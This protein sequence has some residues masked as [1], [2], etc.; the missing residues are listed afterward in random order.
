MKRTQQPTNMRCSLSL[1]IFLFRYEHNFL[2]RISLSLSLSANLTNA[3]GGLSRTLAVCIV[4]NMFVSSTSLVSIGILLL[5]SVC[6]ASLS[7]L[8]K[9]RCATS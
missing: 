8:R 1:S 7:G 4:H 9:K 5:A 3:R 6:M 2:A